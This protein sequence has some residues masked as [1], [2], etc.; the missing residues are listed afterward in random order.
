MQSL[1]ETTNT[2]IPEE[3]QVLIDY[4]QS[5]NIYV[6]PRYQKYQDIHFW[7][8]HYQGLKITKPDPKTGLRYFKLPLREHKKIAL[9]R[10]H[11]QDVFNHGARILEIKGQFKLFVQLHHIHPNPSQFKLIINR[12]GLQILLKKIPLFKVKSIKP[13]HLIQE[14][15]YLSEGFIYKRHY[16]QAMRVL[17][18]NLLEFASL[19]PEMKEELAHAIIEEVQQIHLKGI[20]HADIKPENFCIIQ[21]E[22]GIQA[23]LIDFDDC[24][25]V[26]EIIP[27]Y[28][29][30]GTLPYFAPEFFSKLP[31]YIRTHEQFFRFK[32]HMQFSLNQDLTACL[33]SRYQKQNSPRKST[34]S[35]SALTHER[36]YGF[37][38]L[39]EIKAY[40]K[41]K[42]TLDF[43]DTYLLKMDWRAH[44]SQ[45]SDIYA[46]G[47]ILK[48]IIE[49]P[50][51]SLF[52]EVSEKMLAWEPDKRFDF[53]S[54]RS[55]SPF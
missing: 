36:I 25:K 51:T 11:P 26:D 43:I 45:A 50:Q 18:Q 54:S 35:L 17:G 2:I 29:F 10:K 46:L 12:S 9:Y 5:P 33:V 34:Y 21:N 55:V 8:Q 24:F 37:L 19:H 30:Y 23:K 39:G 40:T 16:Y 49:I 47:C 31:I 13:L 1:F 41:I 3:Y 20:I 32:E 4:L 52:F 15:V 7:H 48:F 44:I 42:L 28:G 27:D 22:K 6:N 38:S 53:L 14:E